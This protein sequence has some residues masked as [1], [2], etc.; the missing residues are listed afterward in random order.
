MRIR[1][2]VPLVACMTT[3]LIAPSPSRAQAPS[4]EVTRYRLANGFEVLL[5]PEPG[6]ARVNVEICYRG[7]AAD[8][9]PGQEGWAHLGEHL[10][11]GG[12]RHLPKAEQNAI[13]SL[14]GGVRD[15][16]TQFDHMAL[17]ASA[18]AN[19]LE[20]LLWIRSDQVGFPGAIDD[21]KLAAEK[22]IVIAELRMRE[23]RPTARTMYRMF[24]LLFPK[25]HPYNGA[26][27][28]DIEAIRRATPA[29]I[30]QF[31]TEHFALSRGFIV[32]AGGFAVDD[33]KR[34][35][36]KY[37]GTIA[38]GNA[39][40]LPVPS[41][42]VVTSELRDTVNEAIDRPR[43]RL[44]W[45][46]PPPDVPERAAVD[47]FPLLLGDRPSSLLANR[48][49]RQQHLAD[50]VTCRIYDAVASSV[51]ACDIT[52]R[53]GVAI[54]ALVREVDATLALLRSG[55]GDDALGRA[56]V[57]WRASTLRDYEELYSRTSALADFYLR[58]GRTDFLREALARTASVTV[59]SLRQAALRWLS[60]DKRVV[61]IAQPEQS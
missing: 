28:G 56:K 37:F 23:R 2:C 51:L 49:V 26:I 53:Q 8:E 18:P 17:W 5:A 6:S 30:R 16:F 35:V 22:E 59:D 20:T 46:I 55:V 3:L 47:L 32:I 10:L 48:L 29:Q 7:G 54:D 15:G 43:L 11:L 1:R 58:T 39:R 52:P 25:P 12:S 21:A 38:G 9:K 45:P 44:A 50:E 40:P 42:A 27:G 14:I 36:D 60:P 61:I 41:P 4:A 13:F 34:L 57:A 33:A 24:A 31:M 19:Q